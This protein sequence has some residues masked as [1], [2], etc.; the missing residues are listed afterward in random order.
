MQRDE[1]RTGEQTQD[2]GCAGDEVLHMW[3]RELKC[4]LIQPYAGTSR[5]FKVAVRL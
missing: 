3:R 4:A 1:D 5:V 2:L